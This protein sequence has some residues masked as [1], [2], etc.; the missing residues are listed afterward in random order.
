MV[1]APA[2]LVSRNTVTPMFVFSILEEPAVLELANIVPAFRVKG[3][4]VLRM[5]ARPAVL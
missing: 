4:L 3:L 2:L 1:A 5:K